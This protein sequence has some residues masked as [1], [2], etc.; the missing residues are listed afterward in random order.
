MYVIWGILLSIL[1]MLSFVFSVE[2]NE[3]EEKIILDAIIDV[4]VFKEDSFHLLSQDEILKFAYESGSEYN[5]GETLRAIT[6]L[7]TKMANHG[8]V[9]DGGI[10]RGITQ[11]QI[12]TAKFILKRLMKIKQQFSDVEIK[13]LLTYNDKMCIILSKY[14]LVYLM[15][16]FKN[17][18]S[19]W[20]HGLLS[21]NVGP[22][23]VS[24]TGLSFDP[25]NYVK[26]AKIFIKQQRK[27]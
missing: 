2:A 25:N 6:F 1:L 3:I 4:K 7:E 23:G 22:G 27:G 5:L 17:H 12:P 19:N 13:M 24:N 9:R 16:R 11:I 14:Y 8:R 21:Y 26:R 20:S 15:D 18:E 10:A